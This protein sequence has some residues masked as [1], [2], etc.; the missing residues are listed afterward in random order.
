MSNSP[1]ISH[2]H[3]GTNVAKLSSGRYHADVA[4][5]GHIKVYVSQPQFGIHITQYGSFLTQD[6]KRLGCKDKSYKYA[7]WKFSQT[8]S[9]F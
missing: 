7:A 8:V 9:F 1:P 5:G 3:S 4:L 6:S 2:P